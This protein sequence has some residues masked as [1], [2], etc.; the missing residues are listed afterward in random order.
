MC[1]LKL[2]IYCLSLLAS[3]YMKKGSWSLVAI[4]AIIGV[5]IVAVY[6][7]LSVFLGRPS[8]G[9]VSVSPGF[10]LIARTDPAKGEYLTGASNMTLYI[11]DRDVP[12][13][14]NCYDECA[15]NWPPFLVVGS[16]PNPLPANVSI[17]ARTDG[18]SMYAYKSMP[19]Y[20]YK[21]DTKPGD[22]V[23]DGV[24]GIWH[25]VKP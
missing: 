8:A 11:F 16:V 25:L 15:V 3:S 22:I 5:A 7:A 6:L 9:T 1:V 18:A 14:S 23:G 17:V 13:V 21:L 4:I 10:D 2:D 19:L 24:G 20:Y 12:G